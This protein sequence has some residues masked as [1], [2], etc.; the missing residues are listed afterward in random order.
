MGVDRRAIASAALELLDEVGLDGLTVRRLAARLD[1]KSPALYWHFRSKQELLDMVAQLLQSRQ[2]LGPPHEGEPWREWL[3]RRARER[4]RLLLSHRDGARLVAGTRP[5]SAVVTA[6]DSELQALVDRGFTPVRAV[7]AIVSLGHYVTGFVLEEQ[8]ERQRYAATGETAPEQMTEPQ[9]DELLK[10][11]PIL[12]AALRDG[13]ELGGEE[14][15]EVGLR[16]LIDG[17]AVGLDI[18]TSPRPNDPPL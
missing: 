2:D 5:G 7:H 17:I 4:R 11:T 6:L 16:M 1:V 10:A 9:R 8:A 3:A 18:D 13:G 12:A 14:A 15:F